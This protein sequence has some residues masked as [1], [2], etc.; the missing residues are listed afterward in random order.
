[1]KNC[2]CLVI[3]VCLTSGVSPLARQ[4]FGSTP[5]VRLHNLMPVPESIEFKQGRL[6]FRSSF[7]TAITG[8]VDK[9]LE[10]AID[11][12]MRRLEGKTGLTLARGFV[13][14][15]ADATLQIECS[16]PGMAVQSPEED[17][18]YSLD[19]DSACARLIAATT[20]GVIRGLET[21]LQL[22]EGGRDGEYFFPSVTVRDKPRFVWRGLLIDC[23]RHFQPIEVIK[24][25]VDGMAAVKLNVLHW[26]LSEDQGFRVESKRFPK[27]QQM[28]SDGLFYS[29]QQIRDVINYARDR[30]I[31][32]VP[33]FDMP[34]HIT[35]WLVGHPELG[36]QP[37]PYH[38]ERRWGVFNASLDPTRDHVYKV[39]DKFWGEI[40]ALFPDPY[41][42]IGGDENNGEDWTSNEKIKEFMEKKGIRGTQALQTYFNQRLL[43]ILK[44]HGKKM[45]GWDEIL[46]PDLPRDIVV[47]SWRGQKSLAE[48]A[49]KG[50]Q[51]ILSNGY[52]LDHMLSAA[53]HYAVDPIA[54][55]S[56]LE[57]SQAGLV[58]GGEACMWGEYIGPETI[59]SRVW[60][61][62]AAIA[63]RFWSPRSVKD[64]KDMYRRLERVSVELEEFGLRHN[65]DPDVLLRRLAGSTD[66]AAIKTLAD[67]VEP[68]KH[69]VRGQAFPA[70]Q[71]TPLTRLVDAARPDSREARRFGR[72]V[73]EFLA[74][75]P[76]FSAR[77]DELVEMLGRWR[78][79]EPEFQIAVDQSPI[80]DEVAPLALSLSKAADAGLEAVTYLRKQASAGVDWRD[81]KLK[82]LS[83]ASAPKG[84]V[85]LAVISPLKALV[86]AASQ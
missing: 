9:R 8:P 71:F 16:G 31:R 67:V 79:I 39:L 22:L 74:D 40:A 54:E 73:E 32:V 36:S 43:A 3:T 49:K 56:G 18:S 75:A 57:P 27:L 84:E 83:D 85:E 48:A 7:T 47:Q 12:A 2:L 52:Y 69:Y 20:V 82:I 26:H 34:G 50:Y 13:E 4:T 21:F 64:A 5:G 61:R 11:R 14:S 1:M 58:L 55:N 23:C 77:R 65:S 28:G 42:H 44:K 66:T 6:P 63:E 62:T 51:G 17:E 41:M 25:N 68:V 59:D 24:R 78:D 81:S 33:E 70:T 86:V 15:S 35:S 10:A 76:R 19:V 80:L 53:T 30:G 45:V 29:Q 46:Q 72:L 38:I 37:G 60:P